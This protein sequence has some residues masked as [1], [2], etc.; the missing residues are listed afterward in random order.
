MWRAWLKNFTT[1]PIGQKGTSETHRL[2]S[3][4]TKYVYLY[5]WFITLGLIKSPPSPRRAF[6]AKIINDRP[7]T[8][9]VRVVLSWFSISYRRD[10][11]FSSDYIQAFEDFL[12]SKQYLRGSIDDTDKFWSSSSIAI[13]F[14]SWPFY[15]SDSYPLTITTIR[16]L[17]SYV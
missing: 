16:L 5:H 4:S 7:I 1:K 15:P 14:F 9:F 10:Y 11:G 6:L 8:L 2:W 3:C 12:I 17:F 13:S